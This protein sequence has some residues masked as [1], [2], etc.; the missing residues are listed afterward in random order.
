LVQARCR[1]PFFSINLLQRN[2]A[3][4]PACFLWTRNSSADF[5]FTCS[6]TPVHLLPP[7]TFLI[8]P[9]RDEE[10][11]PFSLSLSLSCKRRVSFFF[12]SFGKVCTAV[13]SGAHLSL[14]DSPS[15]PLPT[16]RDSLVDFLE[17]SSVFFNP[18]KE[19]GFGSVFLQFCLPL[20]LVFLDRVSVPSQA[21][22]V[23]W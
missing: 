3:M 18:G 14:E 23:L 7:G 9:W 1:P 2:R 13:S 17:P 21:L 10:V 6:R 11:V 20:F 15:Q 22:E 16:E 4:I 5:S 19:Q 8:R 12:G